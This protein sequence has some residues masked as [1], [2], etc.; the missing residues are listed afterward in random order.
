MVELDRRRLILTIIFYIVLGL[1]WLGFALWVVPPLL[2][3]ENPGSILA[4]VRRHIGGVPAPF[5]SRGILSRWREVAAAARS[6]WRF[7]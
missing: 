6:R 7:I 3:V 2:L 1:C 5:L 4:A